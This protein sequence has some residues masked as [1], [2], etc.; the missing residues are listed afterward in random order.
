MSK[1]YTQAHRVFDYIKDFGSISRAEALANL[2]V[3]NLPAVIEELRHKHGYDIVT[4][5]VKAKNRW[6]E[7]ITYA[8]YSFS[9]EKSDGETSY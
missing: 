5:E 3:A 4:N 6:G 2:G 8:R 1:K 7:N 9:E